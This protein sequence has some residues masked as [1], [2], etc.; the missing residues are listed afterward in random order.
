M[1]AALASRSKPLPPSE[2]V[3]NLTGPTWLSGEGLASAASAAALA[4]VAFERSD[5]RSAAA[6]LEAQGLD[7]SEA[8]LLL[9]LLELQQQGGTRACVG[10]PPVSHDIER[11]TGAPATSVDRFF[12]ENAAA[13]TPAG[14]SRAL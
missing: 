2:R 4:P 13:F 11:V 14:G 5:R 7:P 8:V 9:D 6:L 3:L 12:A 1:V 10:A